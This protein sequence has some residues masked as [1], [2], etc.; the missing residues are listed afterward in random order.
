MKSVIILSLC[1]LLFCNSNSNGETKPKNQ[2]WKET[3]C[4]P[5]SDVRDGIP[6]YNRGSVKYHRSGEGILKVKLS[7]PVVIGV[8]EKEE[9]WGYFQFPVIYKDLQ[10]NLVAQWNMSDDAIES[11]GKGNINCSRSTDNGKTW[12]PVRR[13]TIVGGGLMFPDGERIKINTPVALI[14]EEL[15]LPTPIQHTRSPRGY[16]FYRVNELPEKLQGVYIDRLR[17]GNMRWTTEHSTLDDSA[18]VRYDRGG[19]FPVIWWGDIR[20]APDGFVYTGVYPGFFLN[21]DGKVEPS[22][23]NFYKSTDKGHIW[24]LVSRI[25][26]LPDLEADQQGDKR[27]LFGFTEPAFEILSDG[28]FLCVMRTD[29]PMYLTRSLDLGKT[30]TKPKAFTPNGVLPRLLQLENGVVVLASGRPGVQLRFSIDGKGDI[31]TDPFQI[32]P[33]D[34]KKEQVSCGYTE[35][36]ATGHD[37]FLLIYSDFKCPNQSGELRKAIKVREVKVTLLKNSH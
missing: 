19:L 20:I 36:I 35:I 3:G 33:Y 14:T 11:Y 26:Y 25:L 28:S 2:V 16:T 22:G 10:D 8:A 30:W 18:A 4:T 6:A 34:D 23:I 31:W 24:K 12:N 5:F 27:T 9:K 37:R 1:V 7:E 15:T 32:L 21:G 13:E 29:G 17:K